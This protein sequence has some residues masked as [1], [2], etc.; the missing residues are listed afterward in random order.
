MVK[1]NRLES[2]HHCWSWVLIYRFQSHN[3]NGVDLD[4]I[5]EK[6][7]LLTTCMFG[8]GF[9]ENFPQAICDMQ[10]FDDQ[11]VYILGDLNI[12]MKGKHPL[13]KLHKEVCSLHGLTQIIDSP[14][15]ITDETSILIDHILTNSIEKGFTTWSA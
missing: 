14:T 5:V 8:S 2:V 7:V 12:D 3:H 1:E 6:M 11:E 13:A 15:R 10:S 9:L 4:H